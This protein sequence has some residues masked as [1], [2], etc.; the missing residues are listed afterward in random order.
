M[1]LHECRWCFHFIRGISEAEDENESRLTDIVQETILK[2]KLGI[3]VNGAERL[4][5]LGKKKQEGR[6]RP[7]ILKLIDF[8]KK[9]LMLKNTF[10]LK[11][12]GIKISEDFSKRFQNI[13]QRLRERLETE[14]ANGEQIKQVS[15]D[16][17]KPRYI[18]VGGSTRGEMQTTWTFKTIWHLTNKRSP[19]HLTNINARS[20]ADKTTE[21]EQSLLIREPDI[22]IITE[23]WLNPS[24]TDSEIIPSTQYSE[25]NDQSEEEVLHLW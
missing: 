22:V 4:H 5:M 23:T 15:Q 10:K 1:R 12:T 25:M 7:V 9:I 3:T 19:L 6:T 20:I 8:R 21:F 14:R 18:C 17:N 16:Y 24:I 2:D 11:N 13:R